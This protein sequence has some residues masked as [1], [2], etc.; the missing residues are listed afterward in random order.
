MT[1]LRPTRRSVIA[2]ALTFPLLSAGSAAASNAAA[3][4]AALEAASGGRLGAF[5][6]DSRSGRSTGYHADERVAMCSTFKMPLAAAILQAVDQGRLALDTRIAIAKSD[7]LA[8]APVSSQNLERGWMTIADAARAAQQQSD[9]TAANLLLKQLGGPEGFTEF[10][11]SIGDRTT[12]LDNFEPAMNNVPDGSDHNTTSPEAAATTA[13][14]IL[15]GTVLSQAS[16]SLLISWMV[17]TK[18]G[19]KRIRS[20]VPASWRAGDKTGTYLPD[21]YLQHNDVAI[22]W[23][24]LRHTPLIVTAYLRRPSAANWT[25]D[26]SERVLAGVGRM[27]AHWY[28]TNGRVKS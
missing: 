28:G 9:N 3:E 17:E 8:N 27:A 7:I 25:P 23:P 15:T 12:R 13:A 22:L 1:T 6:L 24:P 4:L 14:K 26:D 19:L 11:R 20:G 2:T 10:L 18:T 5:F 16:R 21:E